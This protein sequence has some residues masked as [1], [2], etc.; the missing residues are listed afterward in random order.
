MT[1]GPALVAMD[2][3][4]KLNFHFTNPLI[5][6]GRV[7]F[8]YWGTLAF[9]RFDC[10]GDELHALWCEIVHDALNNAMPGERKGV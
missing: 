7:P 1:P 9:G 10:D 8:F 3:L 5:V 2:W 4:E 6:F